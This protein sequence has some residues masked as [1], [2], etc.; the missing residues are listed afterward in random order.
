MSKILIIGGTGYLGRHL[1][2]VLSINHEVYIT[3]RFENKEKNSFVFNLEQEFIFDNIDF[4]SFDFVFMLASSISGLKSKKIEGSTFDINCLAYK[5]LMNHLVDINFNKNYF[6][7]SSMTVY[8]TN[9]KSPVDESGSTFSP[10]N[11]YGLSKLFAEQ[12]T[13]F[14]CRENNFKGVVIRIPGLFGG[15]RKSGFIYNA[16]NKLSKN[17]DFHISTENLKY[18]ETISVTDA[19]DML[20]EFLNNYKWELDFDIF[21][22]SYGHET[23]IIKLAFFIKEKLDSKSKI[24]TTIPKGY[25][26]FY[27]NNEKYMLLTDN[28][29]KNFNK[30]LLNY[31]NENIQ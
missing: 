2:K 21:N 3:S 15:A 19:S 25:L 11:P 7:I 26:P 9:N 13:E 24:T 17:E 1:S 29:T 27:L 31:I 30:S 14:Y 6:Y 10:P 18:W 12:L 22:V 4:N 20:L 23:D 16:I 8:S 5:N 28:Y